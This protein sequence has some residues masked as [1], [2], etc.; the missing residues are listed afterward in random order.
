MKHIQNFEEFLNESINPSYSGKPIVDKL[1][2]G[3]KIEIYLNDKLEDDYEDALGVK[4]NIVQNSRPSN[5]GIRTRYTLYKILTG[6]NKDSLLFHEMVSS[7]FGT[8]RS[9]TYRGNSSNWYSENPKTYSF[10]GVKIDTTNIPPSLKMMYDEF[11]EI[12]NKIK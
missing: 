7:L 12:L 8:P 11:V 6:P 2:D 9:E 1:S 10:K 3:T 4:A 5:G